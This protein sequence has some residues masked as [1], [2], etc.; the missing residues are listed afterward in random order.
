MGGLEEHAGSEVIPGSLEDVSRITFPRPL[1]QADVEQLFVYIAEQLQCKFDYRVDAHRSIHNYGGEGFKL[2][3]GTVSFGGMITRIKPF[4]VTGFETG[5]VHQDTN[6]V[7]VI[8]FAIGGRDE[9][10]DCLPGEIEF[11]RD[12]RRVACEYFSKH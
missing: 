2:E 3:P 12:I 6:L 10:E 1:A 4:A 5:H 7:E 9:I 8:Q 11:W